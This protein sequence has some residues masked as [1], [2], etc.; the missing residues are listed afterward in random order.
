MCVCLL[1]GSVEFLEDDDASKAPKKLQE[2]GYM[3][4]A[5]PLDDAELDAYLATDGED[6]TQQEQVPA[7]VV[8][9]PPAPA[10][11]A[12][13]QSL[14]S[15]SAAESGMQ[16]AAEAHTG[17]QPLCDGESLKEEPSSASISHEEEEV[18][19]EEEEEEEAPGMQAQPGHWHSTH[20]AVHQ[21][22]GAAAVPA[23]QESLPVLHQPSTAGTSGRTSSSSSSPG[24]SMH[25]SQVVTAGQPVSAVQELQ[26]M[27]HATGLPATAMSAADG[28]DEGGAAR[29]GSASPAHATRLSTHSILQDSSPV[30]QQRARQRPA[31]ASPAIRRSS[32]SNHGPR[33][34]KQQYCCDT[35]SPGQH[36][37]QLQVLPVASWT[38]G[39]LVSACCACSC[40]N[41]RMHA[42]LCCAT[43]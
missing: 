27:W 15:N 5:V 39:W 36:Q 4:S 41:A 30:Q 34:Q 28:L 35:S 3:G 12:S 37:Q 7:R 24:G 16:P 17:Q 25:D 8:D 2:A 21:E 13:Q 40:L 20:A 1:Q 10:A 6:P 43:S 38:G 22:P 31:S 14:T 32:S 23:M 29:S 42:I 26:E 19:Q 18:L 11:A 33:L 9:H